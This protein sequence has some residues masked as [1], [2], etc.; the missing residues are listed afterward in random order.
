MQQQESNG[1]SKLFDPK[2]FHVLI[3]QGLP[4]LPQHLFQQLLKPETPPFAGRYKPSFL[5]RAAFSINPFDARDE[6]D[7]PQKVNLAGLIRGERR[8]AEV[9]KKTP[10]EL[11]MSLDDLKNQMP[12]LPDVS[13]DFIKAKEGAVQDKYG[14]SRQ[15]IVEP[16]PSQS[17]LVVNSDKDDE[18]A[19]ND[20]AGGNKQSMPKQAWSL[21]NEQTPSHLSLQEEQHLKTDDLSDQATDYVN[22]VGNFIYKD[23]N[24]KSLWE[25]FRKSEFSEHLMDFFAGLATGKTPQESFSNAAIIMRQGKNVHAQK[26]PIFEF[27]RSKGYSD[28]DA[29]TIVQVPDLA[30]KIITSLVSSEEGYRTRTA[31]EKAEQGS[32]AERGLQISTGRG[33]MI[34][35]QGGQ[36]SMD[37]EQGGDAGNRFS[38]PETGSMLV[39]EENTSHGI[40]AVPM[41]E[42]GAEHKLIQEQQNEERHNQQRQWQETDQLTRANLAI[43]LAEKLRKKV[44]ESP[45]IVGKIEDWLAKI[46]GT[47]SVQQFIHMLDSLKAN[48]GREVL[49]KAKEFLPN[50][51]AGLGNLSYQQLQALQNSIAALNQDL[52]PEQIKKSLTTVID[53]FNKSNAQTRATLFGGAQE[54]G[55]YVQDAYGK[56]AET[57]KNRPSDDLLEKQIEALPEGSL[58]I[59]RDGHIKEKQSNG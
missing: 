1:I 45:H 16:W 6:S 53:I 22:A 20:I 42:S 19:M 23:K 32:S 10:A 49:R 57:Q 38:K 56:E 24:P 30:Q 33:E 29:K 25:R 11:L 9:G 2:F 3:T 48:I 51:A 54:T 7:N 40:P 50:D 44:E 41:A 31:E 8:G 26:R 18:D 59:D 43:A 27:L 4:Q 14:L 21:V 5:E 58:F 15:K 35:L 47:E 28:E 17:S 52:S 12:P 39:R 55:E 36:N 13:K 37:S 46:P 34:P